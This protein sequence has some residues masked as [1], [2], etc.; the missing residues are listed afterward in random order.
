MMTYRLMRVLLFALFTVSPVG[1]AK[2]YSEI[3]A[4]FVLVDK[5]DRRL[6]LKFKGQIIGSFPVVFGFNPV[7]H[8]QFEGDGRTPEGR[9][10]LDFKNEDS[11]FYKSIRV[12]YPHEADVWKASMRG[13]EPGGD[14]FIHGQKNGYS[15]EELVAKRLHW[16]EGCIALRDE[17]MD[18]VWDLIE[19]RT[20]IVIRP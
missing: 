6:Y 11:R 20:I 15:W 17:H 13:K 19:E 14:I 7:G 4:D 2:S 1:T 8:K 5:S 10:V 9:Y 18:R 3:N 16:T 12:S